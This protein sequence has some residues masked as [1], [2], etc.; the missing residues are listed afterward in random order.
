MSKAKPRSMEPKRKVRV[1]RSKKRRQMDDTRLQAQACELY[2]QGYTQ[3]TIGDR[4][5]IKPAKVSSLLIKLREQWLAAALID[6]DTKKAE[7]LAKIDRLESV[8]W[9]AW[10]RSCKPES[11]KRHRRENEARMVEEEVEDSE[12]EQEGTTLVRRLVPAR[13]I[14]EESSKGRYGDPK[15]LERISWCIDTRLKILGAYKNT[16]TTNHLVIQWDEL[17]KRPPRA[18]NAVE[19]AIKAAA[20]GNQLTGPGM[21]YDPEVIEAEVVGENEAPGGSSLNPSPALPDENETGR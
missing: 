9:E 17:Y 20:Q 19:A 4:L 18:E 13:S 3:A 10:Y 6:F 1:A 21:G 8:A 15:L 16:G 12:G 11:T 5:N 7:E 14:E 2:L